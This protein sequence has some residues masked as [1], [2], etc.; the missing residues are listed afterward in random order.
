MILLSIGFPGSFVGDFASAIKL[1]TA[2]EGRVGSF[3]FVG[4]LL[5]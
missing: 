3:W 1:A 2:C 5:I 4:L